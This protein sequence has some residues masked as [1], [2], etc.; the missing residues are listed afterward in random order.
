M[1]SGHTI[2][3][4]QRLTCQCTIRDIGESPSFITEHAMTQSHFFMS[5]RRQYRKS[6]PSIG[7]IL[8]FG[9]PDHMVLVFDRVEIALDQ[10]VKHP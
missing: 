6:N 9:W 2:Y 5:P 1:I 10:V 8:I 7:C 4:E 3:Q